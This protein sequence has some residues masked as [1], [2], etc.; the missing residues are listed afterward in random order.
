MSTIDQEVFEVM[1]IGV[2]HSVLRE[3]SECPKHSW[4]GAPEA[5][6]QIDPAYWA[7]LEG[8]KAGQDVIVLTWL[9]H[10]DRSVLRV[11]PRGEPASA[12]C[13]VF[14][15][16]SPDRPNPIGLHRLRILEIPEP[17]CLRVYPL[18]I[19]DGTP[20]IDIKPV[21]SRTADA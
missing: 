3:R 9:H 2:V 17:G 13:G 5:W 15:T 11:R 12:L 7:A 8:V 10:A 4:L 6:I 16:R 20:V 1:P 19:I 14:H 21:L 18:E